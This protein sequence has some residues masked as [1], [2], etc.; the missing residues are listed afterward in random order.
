MLS[1]KYIWQASLTARISDWTRDTMARVR[2]LRK[3][4]T[5]IAA[6]KPMIATTISNSISVNPERFGIHL[7]SRD[8]LR[9]V[10]TTLFTLTGGE[11]FPGTSGVEIPSIQRVVL[12]PAR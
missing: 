1:R 8:Y 3:F 9:P 12:I 5:A 4:G 10:N 7:L 11:F 2:A 6:R